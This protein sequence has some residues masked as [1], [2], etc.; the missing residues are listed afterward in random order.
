[1]EYKSK[2]KKRMGKKSKGKKRMGK[3]KMGRKRMVGAIVEEKNMELLP[4]PPPLG[5]DAV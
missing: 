1:M 2:G 4:I 3:K 5:V